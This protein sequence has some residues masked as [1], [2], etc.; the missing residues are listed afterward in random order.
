MHFLQNLCKHAVVLSVG[1]IVQI[2][3]KV[4]CC[5]SAKNSFDSEVAFYF[6]QKILGKIIFDSYKLY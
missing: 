5:T 6:N 2:G 1:R 3:H 4:S